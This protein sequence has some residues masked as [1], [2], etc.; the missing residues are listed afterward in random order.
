MELSVALNDVYKSFHPT[1][2]Q[3]VPHQYIHSVDGELS[4]STEKKDHLS[5]DQLTKLV[6]TALYNEKDVDRLQKI[7][8]GYEE[9]KLH[10]DIKQKTSL[11]GLV[12]YHLFGGYK[13][14]RESTQLVHQLEQRIQHI[15]NTLDQIRNKN[16][17][18]QLDDLVGDNCPEDISGKLVRLKESG[19]DDAIPGTIVVITKQDGTKKFGSV[20]YNDNPDKASPYH[21]AISTF[22]GTDGKPIIGVYNLLEDEI[23]TIPKDLRKDMH[24][25]ID[26]SKVKAI[27]ERINSLEKSEQNDA[28]ETAFLLLY[29]GNKSFI[30]K[31]SEIE[32]F[33]DL[34]E[35]YGKIVE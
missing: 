3:N 28:T 26:E 2:N 8:D 22:N 13:Q 11:W 24:E 10:F 15:H 4:V 19:N 6:Q 29:S 18:K 25:K 33:K 14:E 27:K 7:K 30:D 12:K 23:Y 32:E 5:F 31:H 16:S 1:E 9:I 21:L 17:F 20:H 34:K 35:K